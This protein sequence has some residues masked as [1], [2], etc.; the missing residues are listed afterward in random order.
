MKASL[1]LL[2]AAFTCAV[3]AT[4]QQLSTIEEGYTLANLARLDSDCGGSLSTDGFDDGTYV[5]YDGV[6]VERRSSAGVILQRYAS[7]ATAVFPSFVKISPDEQTILFGES[8]SGAIYQ[9]PVAGGV[10]TF[11]TTLSF[12][13][14]AAFDVDPNFVYINASTSGFGT[15]SIHRVD[16]SA[17]T[18]EELVLLSGF[19]GPIATTAAGDVLVG[20]LPDVFPFPSGGTAVALY[21]DAQLDGGA[22]L[23]DADGVE[24]VPGLNGMSSLEY[25]LVGDRIFLMETN[26]GSSGFD[27]LVRSFD[28]T[29]AH[30]GNIAEVAGFAGGLELA[31]AGLGLTFGPY[32]PPFASLR[33]QGSDCFGSGVFERVEVVGARPRINWTGPS[34]GN[35]DLATF[36]LRGAPAN[37]FASLWAA[38]IALFTPNTVA[39]TS[40]G[41]DYALALRGPD[42][43]FIRRFA[44]QPID[45]N[46]EADLTY[47]QDVAAEGGFFAQWIVFDENMNPLTTTDAAINR[48]LF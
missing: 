5:A 39:S 34:L 15:T 43:S 28:D 20:R 41:G 16:L 2:A 6:N 9:V 22:L 4:A 32:Q 7:F 10:P 17:G 11:V 1:T 21:T 25:D 33:Y 26:S 19:S 27:T 23:G 38:R 13:F 3:P 48:S 24:I 18:S 14:D 47:F 44:I 35:S 31:S 37:G 45:A 12:N 46:G 8:S 29:G 40:L 30:L 36:E 42:T